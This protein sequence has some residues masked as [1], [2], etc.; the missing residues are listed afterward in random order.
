MGYYHIRL[1]KQASNLCTN[2]IPWGKYQYKHLPM[3]V[4]NSPDIFL[5]KMNKMFRGFELIR[6]YINNMLIITKGDWSDHAEKLKLTLKKLKDN[7]LNY[8]IER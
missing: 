3:G 6:A 4:S 2:I 5:E 1:R 8:N 7:D